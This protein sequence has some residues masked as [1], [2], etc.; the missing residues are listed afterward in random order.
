MVRPAALVLL[1]L[2][3]PCLGDAL[4]VVTDAD[5]TKVRQRCELLVKELKQQP[6]TLPAE[7]ERQL[8]ALLQ[9]PPKDAE[10][11]LAKLQALLDPLCLVGIHINAESRVKVA[12][13]PAAAELIRGRTRVVLLKVHNEGGITPPL[14][15]SGE[16]LRRRDKLEPG[17]WLEAA[18]LDAAALKNL[19]GVK[20]EYVALRLTAHEAGK[21]EATLKFD[22]GQ[23]TQD[24]GFRA[25]VAIL[26]KIGR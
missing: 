20:L 9:E 11:G 1:F 10:T 6:G 26:F 7:I 3:P 15:V 19:S 16:V 21:R 24:L 12:R 2:T 4:P 17:R 25:E 23:G 13:G 14:N 5:W 8:A 18:P 22:A